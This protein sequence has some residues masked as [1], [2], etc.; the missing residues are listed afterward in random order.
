MR[1]SLR[2]HLQ[3]DRRSMVFGRPLL[4]QMFWSRAGMAPGSL[5][6]GGSFPKKV[7]KTHEHSASSYLSGDSLV[8]LL[9]LG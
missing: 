1:G 9:R 8:L 3:T 6:K 5:T 4:P 7:L 2:C